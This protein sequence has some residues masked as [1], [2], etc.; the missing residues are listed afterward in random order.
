MATNLN[1]SL[2]FWGLVSF[3]ILMTQ[4]EIRMNG[5]LVTEILPLTVEIIVHRINDIMIFIYVLL[6]HFWGINVGSFISFIQQEVNF[7]HG[8]FDSPSQVANIL[9]KYSRLKILLRNILC[10]IYVLFMYFMYIFI[11]S[12]AI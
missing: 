3:V 5:C 9:E 11:S 10:Y 1:G 7:F 2:S 12:C 4:K 8:C 6:V